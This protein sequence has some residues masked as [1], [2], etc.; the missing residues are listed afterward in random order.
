MQDAFSDKSDKPKY[1]ILRDRLASDIKSGKLEL[2]E[3][4]PSERHL[5]EQLQSARMTVRQALQMLEGEGMISRR[6]N[7]GWYVDT[8]RIRYDPTNHINVTQLIKNHGGDPTFISSGW[9]ISNA[10]LSLAQLFDCEP[11]TELLTH[12]AVVLWNGRKIVYDENHLLLEHFPEFLTMKFKDPL[13][14]FLAENFGIT[15]EQV[16]FRS[17]TT[18]LYGAIAEGLAITIGTPGVF[19]TR[20]KSHDGIV[21]QIDRDFWVSGTLEL[22]VG[23]LP[24]YS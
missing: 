17:R 18:R 16:G 13:T 21:K 9:K 10:S 7:R 24:P 5:A 8:K 14:D 12:H 20:I 19:N 3:R 15:M 2:G 11:G 22:C 23:Q 4:L 6:G 1:Q